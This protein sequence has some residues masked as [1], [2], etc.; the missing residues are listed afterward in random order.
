MLRPEVAALK[1]AAHL[2]CRWGLFISKPRNVREAD[3]PFPEPA[4]FL[5]NPEGY[6]HICEYSNS[7]F[8]R[9]DLRILIE[10]RRGVLVQEHAKLG[11][12]FWAS[13]LLSLCSEV[14]GLAQL[15][16]S[17]AECNVRLNPPAPA[18]TCPS[19]SR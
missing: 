11:H 9:P 8:S 14:Q 16:C 1:A 18:A 6:V 7:P 19:S 4:M 5:L 3:G 13:E 10:G 15:G 12:A 17:V 2:P